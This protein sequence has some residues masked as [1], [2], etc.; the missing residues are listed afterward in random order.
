MTNKEATQKEEEY[1]EE[2]LDEKKD[3]PHNYCCPLICLIKKEV[4][5]GWIKV[6]NF[7]GSTQKFQVGSVGDSSYSNGVHDVRFFNY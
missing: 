5:I 4:Y 7:V 1:L 3:E 6:E 2:N